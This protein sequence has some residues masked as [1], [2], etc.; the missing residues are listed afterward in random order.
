MANKV[1]SKVPFWRKWNSILGPGLLM[2]AA[3]IGVSHLVQSTRAGA[4]YGTQLLLL[5]LLTNIFKYPFFEYGHRYPAATGETLLQGY[6]RLGK[7]YLYAFLFLN[8]INA[9]ASV[10]AVTFVTGALCQNLFSLGIPLNYWCVLLFVVCI[11]LLYKGEYKLLDNFGKILMSILAVATALS[12]AIAV[13]N[14]PV[15]SPNFTSPSPWSM[16][17]LP[18]LIALMGWMPAPIELSVWQS[19]WMKAKGELRGQRIEMKEAL[20]DFN[21]GYILTIIMAVFFLLLGAFIMHGSGENFSAAPALFA[22]QVVNLYTHSLG[23]WSWILISAAAFSTMFSTTITLVD[24]YPRSVSEGLLEAFPD[25]LKPKFEG[26]RGWYFFWLILIC[27]LSLIIITFFLNQLKQL[28]DLVTSLAFVTGPF[29]AFIN[30]KLIKSSW[31]PKEFRP[32]MWIY[33][34]SWV[35]LAYLVGFT[36]LYLM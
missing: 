18:F 17:A 33:I 16:A 36:T 4:D 7:F 29:F 22:S 34:L 12:L 23:D 21:F 13:L 25:S 32:P 11:V 14:G 31:V 1:P 20:I 28:V 3:A 6:R 5:V 24:A 9:V 30:F 19:L 27:S 26:H 10:A 15:K 8:F 2:A 35:G